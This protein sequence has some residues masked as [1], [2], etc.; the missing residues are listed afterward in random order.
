MQELIRSLNNVDLF[1]DKLKN[2]MTNVIHGKNLK[3]KLRSSLIYLL[4]LSIGLFLFVEE[5]Q[6]NYFQ[7]KIFLAL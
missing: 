4:K 2:Y 7:Q 1:K 5:N 6:K 3:M